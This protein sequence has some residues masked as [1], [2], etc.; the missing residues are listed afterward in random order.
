MEET[1]KWRIEKFLAWNF[2]LWKLQLEALLIQKDHLFMLEGKSN[3]LTEMS[4]ED[5]EILDRMA[6]V[7]IILSLSSNVLFNI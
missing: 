3:K 7:M 1:N 5:S 4:D 2:R 6:V